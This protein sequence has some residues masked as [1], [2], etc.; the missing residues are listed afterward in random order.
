MADSALPPWEYGVVSE[1]SASFKQLFVERVAHWLPV[2]KAALG[3]DARWARVR[4][5]GVRALFYFISFLNVFCVA[6]RFPWWFF[7]FFFLLL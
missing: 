6:H 3:H 5:S 4:G 7:F 1:A 2:L